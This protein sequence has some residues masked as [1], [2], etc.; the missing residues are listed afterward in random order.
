[1]CDEW[2]MPYICTVLQPRPLQ[3]Q[4]HRC[5]LHSSNR[6][7]G[8]HCFIHNSALSRSL[9]M[10]VQGIKQ[11]EFWKEHQKATQED[12][13]E[14]QNTSMAILEVSKMLIEQCKGNQA[15]A[16]PTATAAND[17]QTC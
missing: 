13:K 16:M 5:L 6:D 15:A 9:A 8:Y 17:T 7:F 2:L 14:R 11:Q 12:R 4:Q 3:V 1:M 10:L